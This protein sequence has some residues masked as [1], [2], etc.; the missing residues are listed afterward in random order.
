MT[1]NTIDVGDLGIYLF[2]DGAYYIGEQY[3]GDT[4][5]VTFGLRNVTDNTIHSENRDGIFAHINYVGKDM[6]GSTSVHY[7][8]FNIT[9]N[10]ITSD[11]YALHFEWEEIGY[12]MYEDSTVTI[13]AVTISNN[14]LTSANN[15]ALFY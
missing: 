13:G 10:T 11:D 12:D 8:D 2:S 4:A 7:G 3:W 6:Y 1:N 14:T 9:G 15:D 5:S